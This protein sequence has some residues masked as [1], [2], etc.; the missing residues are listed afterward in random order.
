MIWSP[1]KE[2]IPC[3]WKVRRLPMRKS[4]LALLFPALCPLLLA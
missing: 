3:P 4:F 1:S 2:L